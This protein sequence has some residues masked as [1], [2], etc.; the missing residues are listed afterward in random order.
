[1]KR[2]EKWKEIKG[3]PY[4]VSNF[5]RV[6]RNA[7]GPGTHIGKILKQ[8]FGGTGYAYVTFSKNAKLKH[9]YVQC[10]VAEAFIGPRPKGYQVNHKDGI[11]KNNFDWNLE[12]VTH[13]ENMEHAGKNGL[14]KNGESHH[15]S[16]LTEKEVLKIRKLYRSGNYTQIKLA[17]RFDVCDV[18]IHE[19]VR[20]KSWK[21][22]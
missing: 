7:P 2:K 22:I 13:K 3:W 12:Y 1:M 20:N 19:I 5:G 16:K 10:L 14:M 9:F 8:K 17:K 21:H 11:K 15:R 6:K 18:T 4:K